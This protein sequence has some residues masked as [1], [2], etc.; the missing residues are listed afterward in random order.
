MVFE[1]PKGGMELMVV[2]ETDSMM[3][4]KVLTV[5]VVQFER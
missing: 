1:R 3:E 5:V 4:K 2:D